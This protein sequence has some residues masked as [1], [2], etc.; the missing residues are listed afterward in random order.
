M[1]TLTP[2]AAHDRTM[3]MDI[4]D[5]VR[6]LNGA[7]GPTLVAALAGSKDRKLPIRWAKEDGPEPRVEASRRLTFA[8]RQWLL[9][10]AADGEHV[11]RQWFI[12]SNPQLHEDTPITA[13]REDRRNDVAAAVKAFIE[14]SAAA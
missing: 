3:R 14:G 11:A 8:H 9:L 5:I 10:A 12:G 1:E 2:T 13:I 6:E 4:H 7:L